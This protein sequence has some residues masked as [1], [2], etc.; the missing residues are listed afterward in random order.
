MFKRGD[1]KRVVVP[2]VMFNYAGHTLDGYSVSRIAKVLGVPVKAAGR[3]WI[4]WQGKV[5]G[6]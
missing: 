1:Y 2:A 4:W 3:F 5:A 6:Y